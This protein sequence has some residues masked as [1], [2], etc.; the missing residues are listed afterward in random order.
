MIFRLSLILI[1]VCNTLQAQIPYGVEAVTTIRANYLRNGLLLSEDLLDFQLNSRIRT[2]KTTDFDISLWQGSEIGGD[3]EETGLFLGVNKTFDKL[4]ASAYVAYHDLEDELFRS[5]TELGISLNY[6]LSDHFEVSSKVFYDDADEATVLTAGLSYSEEINDKTFVTISAEIF[7]SDSYYG[8][9]GLYSSQLES[10]L[11][12]N[13]T[14]M[15]SLSP[16][17]GVNFLDDQENEFVVH[18]GL[19]FE[20][21]F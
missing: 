14:E 7:L 6:E 17:V 5:G 8:R 15:I 13:L 1:L 12:Y 10:V 20:V 19:Y 11:T 4:V 16:F 18:G 9:E 2:S 21:F 3:F